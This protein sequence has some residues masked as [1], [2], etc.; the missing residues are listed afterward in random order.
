MEEKL[1]SQ[2]STEVDVKAEN[3]R[4]MRVSYEEAVLDLI[5]Y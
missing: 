2:S 1:T 4:L 3:E 5:Q